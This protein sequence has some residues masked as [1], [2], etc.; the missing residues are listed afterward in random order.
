LERLG[1]QWA[2]GFN[3]QKAAEQTLAV[4]HEVAEEASVGRIPQ[5]VRAKAGA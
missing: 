3:W 4:Y 1:S 2:A 5:A